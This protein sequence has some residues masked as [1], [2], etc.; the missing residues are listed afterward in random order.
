VEGSRTPTGCQHIL[1]LLPC[2]VC[3]S[4][5]SEKII[6]LQAPHARGGVG[7]CVPLHPTDHAAAMEVV[8]HLLPGNSNRALEFMFLYYMYV[9]PFLQV[10]RR[11]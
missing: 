2:R 3:V 5:K 1:I 6:K 11:F 8:A 9:D 7:R 4:K 10:T